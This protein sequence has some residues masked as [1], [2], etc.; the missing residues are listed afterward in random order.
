[1]RTSIKLPFT[2]SVS[3]IQIFPGI[4]LYI[5]RCLLIVK[6]PGALFP[7]IYFVIFTETEHHDLSAQCR[8]GSCDADNVHLDGFFRDALKDRALVA[9][10]SCFFDF[11]LTIIPLLPARASGKGASRESFCTAPVFGFHHH[12]LEPAG[13]L[14][15]RCS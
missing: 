1:L 14:Y 9:P 12:T 13:L 11:M 6:F 15:Q 10:G 8:I 2:L 3:F 7:D 5:R 4:N